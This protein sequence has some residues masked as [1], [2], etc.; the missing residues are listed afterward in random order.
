[1][2]LTTPW[3]WKAELHVKQ[4]T[5]CRTTVVSLNP[6][7]SREFCDLTSAHCLNSLTWCL[8]SNKWCILTVFSV[9]YLHLTLAST[10]LAFCP[11]PLSISLLSGYHHAL[12]LYLNT[13]Q[14]AH[15]HSRSRCPS[16]FM[17]VCV[18][19][20]LYQRLHLPGHRRRH[21]GFILN[22][23]RT[24]GRHARMLIR[25]ARLERTR[26]SQLNYGPD[27]RLL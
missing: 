23:A 19:V 11:R 15:A 18:A 14:H 27:L 12:Y 6:E 21:G 8:T 26:M 25:P 7:N 16:V 3:G 20:C 5:E 1:M 9:S 17:S 10:V 2:K 24:S 13:E 4:R 22:W